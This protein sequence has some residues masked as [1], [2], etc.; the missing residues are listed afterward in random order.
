M[1]KAR[2]KEA[3]RTLQS[4]VQRRRVREVTDNHLDAVA[5]FLSR[6]IRIPNEGIATS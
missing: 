3:A 6:P 2:E 4:A 5:E 1:K